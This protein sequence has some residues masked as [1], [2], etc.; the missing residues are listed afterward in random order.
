VKLGAGELFVY[1]ESQRLG[2]LRTKGLSLDKVAKDYSAFQVFDKAV[3]EL[4]RS[5]GLEKYAYVAKKGQI[6]VWH[7][8]L[9]HG[10][11]KRSNPQSSRLSIVSHYFARGSVAYYDARGE[12]AALQEIRPVSMGSAATRVDSEGSVAA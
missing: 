4:V 2:R 12:A 3:G 8:N 7:E 10:G 5:N 1:P 6:L 11:E 9:I